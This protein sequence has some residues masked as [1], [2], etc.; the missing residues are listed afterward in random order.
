MDE[1]AG[2]YVIGFGIESGTQESLNKSKKGTTIES[3]ERAIRLCK[4]NRIKSYML[5]MI[6]FPWED[7]KMIK[8]TIN[9][10][11]K[12]DGDFVDF[13]VAYPYPGS[14]MYEMAKKDNLFVEKDLL[15]HDISRSMLRTKYVSTEELMKLRRNAYLGFYLRPKISSL[16]F[17]T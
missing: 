9:F 13:N 5:F 15:E 7:K 10:A 12:L 17:F 11:K 14:E 1:K 6:G 2:C 4:K 8:Q 3:A 16:P